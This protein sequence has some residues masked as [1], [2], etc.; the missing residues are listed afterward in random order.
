MKKFGIS[1]L[2]LTMLVSLFTATA[3]A[4]T[5]TSEPADLSVTTGAVQWVEDLGMYI[6][7]SGINIYTS[8]DGEG[9]ALAYTNPN[10]VKM[11]DFAAGF[12]AD[13]RTS[14]IATTGGK[15]RV[16]SGNSLTDLGSVATIVHKD[17]TVTT[18][19]NV[20]TDNTQNFRFLNLK[21]GII[22]DEYTKKFYCGGMETY[23]YYDTATSKIAWKYVDIGIYCTDGIRLYDEDPYLISDNN[24]KINSYSS[25]MLWEKVDLGTSDP[26][27]GHI[28]E[29][30]EVTPYGD[31]TTNNK[32]Q[33]VFSNIGNTTDIRSKIL[34]STSYQN[35]R[36]MFVI[37][38]MNSDAT[39]KNHKTIASNMY[40]S[41]I[42]FTEGDYLISSA[43]SGTSPYYTGLT[44]YP[45]STLLEKTMDKKADT[46]AQIYCEY[47]GSRLMDW[48]NSDASKDINGNIMSV[49]AGKLVD[50]GGLILAFPKT[51]ATV[52][53]GYENDI[54][55]ITYTAETKPNI[56]S[57]LINNTETLNTLFGNNGTALTVIDVAEGADGNVVLLTSGGIRKLS[58]S[59]LT[60]LD[61]TTKE[62]NL[63][64]RSSIVGDYIT[65]QAKVV[66]T[67]PN[68]IVGSNSIGTT[69]YLK[70]CLK[71]TNKYVETDNAVSVKIYDTV[72]T[73][74]DTCKIIVGVFKDGRL[75]NVFVEDVEPGDEGLVNKKVS[76]TITL[77]DETGDSYM[78]Y[79]LRVFMW[80]EGYNPL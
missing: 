73:D 13:G 80:D 79:K 63:T 4:A 37:L 52:G 28:A 55:Y 18:N 26:F 76:G 74:V 6:L 1:F 17:S 75:T 46:T 61:S 8:A 54:K 65:K 9:W 7:V 3:F 36:G 35:L 57:S 38:D 5:D 32:G 58:T 23:A 20:T 22:Y 50:L 25:Y 10:K 60:G 69:G 59:T 15:N 31:I 19:V 24:I 42:E 66:V 47:K 44:T 77:S 33:L 78:N 72:G 56:Y 71:T 68:I 2:I 34:G 48:G 16:I 39:V 11:T 30:S 53:S 40:Y 29:M 51:G 43:Q 62:E 45:L 41:I 70:N 27:Y 14:I 12:A 21:T 64:D 49:K 67:T